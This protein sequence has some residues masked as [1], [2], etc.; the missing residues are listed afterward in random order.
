MHWSQ[1]SCS[2]LAELKAPQGLKQRPGKERRF[3]SSHFLF[4]SCKNLPFAEIKSSKKR[5]FC[6]QALQRKGQD[7]GLG[8]GVFILP[9]NSK[10]KFF[11]L[12]LS[13]LITQEKKRR[14]KVE[15]KFHLVLLLKF[16]FS[17][18]ERVLWWTDC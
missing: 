8:R 12:Q 6:C 3:S 17:I 10:T 16:I 13:K 4:H 1:R 14:E 15:R 2:C 18:S 11:R 5:S 9:T 7:L